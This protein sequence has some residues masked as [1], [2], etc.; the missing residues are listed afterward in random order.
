VLLFRLV[1]LED[2][3]PCCAVNPFGPIH[4]NATS[5]GILEKTPFFRYKAISKPRHPYTAK[6]VTVTPRNESPVLQLKD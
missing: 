6:P 4:D 3:L 5:P 2:R 1:Q